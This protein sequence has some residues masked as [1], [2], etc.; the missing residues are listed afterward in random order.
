MIA[1]DD[2][3]GV[4]PRLTKI[5]VELR[6][7]GAAVEQY[8]RQLQGFVAEYHLMLLRVIRAWIDSLQNPMPSLRLGSN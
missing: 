6:A 7:H 8:T 1:L 4:F 3:G 5:H 2:G